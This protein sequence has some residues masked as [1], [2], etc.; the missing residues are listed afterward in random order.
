MSRLSELTA[1]N[2]L[3]FLSVAI[4]EGKNN[5]TA[6][7]TEVMLFCKFLSESIEQLV[8]NR[9]VNKISDWLVAS[10]Q[11]LKILVFS[12]PLFITFPWRET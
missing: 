4:R 8:E 1:A 3:L 10:V 11:L 7:N 9:Q 2:L 6:L 12:F 5:L